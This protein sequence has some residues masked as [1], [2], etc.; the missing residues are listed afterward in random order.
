MREVWK[1]GVGT[2]GLFSINM[3]EGAQILTVGA[4]HDVGHMWALVDP[5]APRVSRT[6]LLTGTGHEIDGTLT[7]EYVGTFQQVNGALVWH[8]FEVAACS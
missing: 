3:P 6:F 7:V 8:V 1:Y 2:F 5:R 4:Q